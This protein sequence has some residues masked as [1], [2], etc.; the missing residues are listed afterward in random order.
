[1]D[2]FGVLRLSLTDGGYAWAFEPIDGFS[3]TDQ[4]SGTCHDAPVAKP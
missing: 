4:G 3:F 2:T 1:V